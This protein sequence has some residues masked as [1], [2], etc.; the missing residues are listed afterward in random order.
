MPFA[1]FTIW[2]FFFITWPGQVMVVLFSSMWLVAAF[3]IGQISHP[4]LST[5]FAIVAGTYCLFRLV[6]RFLRRQV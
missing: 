5:M 2:R 4:K 6:S 1:P 3:Q